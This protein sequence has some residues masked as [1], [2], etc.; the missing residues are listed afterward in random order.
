MKKRWIWIG[1][2]V[3]GIAVMGGRFVR[4][5]TPPTV[6]THVLTATRVEQTISC[7]GVVEAA[8]GIG[9]FVPVNCYIREIRVAEGQR[10]R[11]GD[12]LAVIDKERTRTDAGDVAT[13]VALAAIE[14]ELTAPEDGIV[15]EVPAE[16]GE[17]LELGTPCAILVRACD[18]RV[19]IAIREKDLRI[20]REGMAVRLSGDGLEQTSYSGQLTEISSAASTSSST[21]VVEG[22]VTPDEGQADDSFRL[23]ISA[24][25]M[26]I[27]AV[28]ESGYVVPYEAVQTDEKGSFVYV[29]QDGVAHLHR[30][31]KAIQVPR[32][33]LMEDNSLA[34]ATIVMEPEKV[35]GDGMAV[36]GAAS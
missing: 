12:V 35:S 15:V 11:Q 25:A 30:I 4:S 16:V 2:V 36:L 9:V 34:G 33:L 27:T 8:D 21:T 19:R 10:V 7:N 28:T 3:I 13:Q 6:K 23:G 20:L 31:K 14:E 32:G 1:A 29:L 18:L 17:K 22:V 26:V 24:K 5:D